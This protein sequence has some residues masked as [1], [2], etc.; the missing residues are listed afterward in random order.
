MLQPQ[1]M[2]LAQIWA[3]FQDEM[4]MLSV[5][6]NLLLNLESFV[7]VSYSEDWSFK[8]S[9]QWKCITTSITVADGPARRSV[10]AESLAVH[11]DNVALEILMELEPKCIDEIWDKMKGMLQ[12][13]FILFYLYYAVR[14]VSGKRHKTVE[15]PTSVHLSEPSVDSCCCRA[16]CGPRKFWSDCEE[17]Q[18]ICFISD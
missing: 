3:K 2:H 14:I 15:C 6:S 4:V 11:N 1:F 9:K 16:T 7:Q 12:K 17:V 8:F 18:H 10:S 5:L 13:A